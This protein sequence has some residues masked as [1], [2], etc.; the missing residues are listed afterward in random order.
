MF[1]KLRMKAIKSP[2]FI[3]DLFHSGPIVVFIWKNEAG[4]PVESVTDNLLTIF[5]DDPLAYLSGQVNYADRIHPDDISRVFQEVST[6][7]NNPECNSFTH[8]PYRY[9]DGFGKYCWVKDSSQI[10]RSD[11]GNITHYIGYLLD[12]SD[13]IKLQDEANLFK[14]RLE[15][16]WNG[17][18]DGLWDWDIVHDTIYLSTRWKEM[19]GY[20]PDE[21]PNE[22]NTFLE[23]IH[24]ED[25]PLVEDLLKRHISDPENVPYEI[26]MRLCCKNQEYKWI[27]SRGKAIL[28]PDGTPIRMTG[29]HTDISKNVA[30]NKELE[31]QK[32]LYQHLVEFASDGIFIMNLDGSLFQCSH[33][34]S[35]LLGYSM[36]EM[37]SL[38]VY[39]WDALSTK[40]DVL[41]EVSNAPKSQHSFET[42]HRRKDGSIYDAAI[43]AVRIS[44]GDKEYVYASVRDITEAKREQ[45]EV[46]NEKNFIS[47]IL[48]NTNA[49]IAVINQEGT[50]VRL[51]RCG[52][53][54][55]GYT[56]DEVSSEPY[57]W[58]R[59]LDKDIQS[60]VIDIVDKA[61]EGKRVNIFQNSWTSRSGERRMY[62]WSNTI[63]L[64]RDGEFN[65]LITAG[66][67]ITELKVTINTLAEKEQLLNMV[68]S[69]VSEG[70]Y[71]MDES[72]K[73][74]FVNQSFLQILGYEDKDEILGKNIHAMIHHTKSDGSVYPYNEC[75]AYNCNKMRESCHVDDE[76]FWKRDGTPIDVEYW[77]HPVDNDLYHGSVITFLDISEE[78]RLKLETK[79]QEKQ[80]LQQSRFAQMGEMISMIAHQ[81]RQ[82]LGAI[83]ATSINMKFS[84]LLKS[85]DL[86][87]KEGQ[88]E[89]NISFMEELSE[90]EDY[91]ENLT[92][93][94]DDFRNFYKPDKKLAL[95]SFEEVVQ[96]A[97]RIIRSSM[98]MDNISIIEE[99]KDDIKLEMYDNE[100]M[101]VILNILKN[102]HDNFKEKNIT[103]PQIKITSTSAVL[104]ISDNGGGIPDEILDKIFDPYFSTKDEKNGTGLGLYMSKIIIEEHHNGKL[105]AKNQDGGTLFQISFKK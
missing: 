47:T 18:G 46:E 15:L 103:N 97:L 84:L 25:L 17:V 63:V 40:E 4:W 31:D 35:E 69:S 2:V 79:K 44:I 74:I 39:D 13:D 73:C 14:E 33:H 105:R 52:E 90:I 11:S 101:Q 1:G 91:V 55:T 64:N 88:D 28:G 53:E 38:H 99:Y 54:F 92:A 86:N 7:S 72:G 56:Q 98:E 71:G 6:A 27:N 80:M 62:E 83:A 57:F 96:K 32:Q 67:D 95:V 65:Y 30:L 26:D 20:S 8:K 50:M 21:L 43:T 24:P 93:T 100:V 23:A 102:A 9:L 104:D 12:I 51:N 36:E 76:V 89:L 68:L 85:F 94:I 87:T 70:I 59:F 5:G 58:K 49:I 66:I 10:I 77:S 41:A 75:R 60:K 19:L 81:W 37:K 45:I 78:N 48:S 3:F 22:V 34:A 82:P 61:K 42:K 29:I 16:T